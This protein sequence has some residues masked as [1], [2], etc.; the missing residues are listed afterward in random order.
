MKSKLET[1][2]ESVEC[3]SVPLD[4]NSFQILKE[5]LEQMLKDK[6]IES[7]EP[8]CES[9]KQSCQSFQDPIAAILDDMCS[10]SHFDIQLWIEKHL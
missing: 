7:Q 6:Y 1:R 4:Y 2:F 8:S 10:Q 5:T 9:M 3:N